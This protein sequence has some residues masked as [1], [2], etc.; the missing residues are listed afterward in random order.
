MRLQEW[1]RFPS[2]DDRRAAIAKAHQDTFRWILLPAPST[3]N[4]TPP[5]SDFVEWLRSGT[6]VY[7]IQGKMGCG[8]ST[9]MKYVTEQEL[10]KKHLRE[11]A[12]GQTLHC[13]SYYFSKIGTSE[14]QQSLQGLYRT[15]LATLIRHEKGLFRVAFPDRQASD[16]TH[17][18][19]SAVLRDALEKILTNSDITCKY[20]FFIDGL[21]E[22]QETDNGL[23]GELAEDILRLARLSAVKLVVASRP[24]PIF[25][26]NFARCLTMKLHNLTGNDIAAYVDARIRRRA[27]PHVLTAIDTREL[28]TLCVEVIQK[29]EGVFLWVTIAVASILTGIADYETLPELRS[30]FVQLDP[31]LSVLFKQVLTERIQASHRKQVARCLLAAIVSGRD[32][33]YWR[34]FSPANYA[35][36]QATIPHSDASNDHTT[37]LGKWN[38]IEAHIVDLQRSLPG[39]SCGLFLGADAWPTRIPLDYRV[40][41]PLSLLHSSL[42]EFLEERKTKAILLKEA[43]D[44]F[45][46]N[47]AIAVGRMADLVLQIEIAPTS[48]RHSHYST[49]DLLDILHSIE[50]AEISTYV[51]QTSLI[52]TFDNTLCRVYKRSPEFANRLKRDWNWDPLY[53]DH[54]ID[55]DTTRLA[56]LY[57]DYPLLGPQGASYHGSNILS[58]SIAFGFSCY[59]EYKMNACRGLPEKTGTPLL[60]YPLWTRTNFFVWWLSKAGMKASSFHLRKFGHHDENCHVTPVKLLLTAGADPNELCHGLTPWSVLL[61]RMCSGREED[62]PLQRLPWSKYNWLGPPEQS[63]QRFRDRLEVARL[64]LDH[65]ADPFYSM[66]TPGYTIS[67]QIFAELLER[68]CCDGYELNRCSCSHA[69]EIQPRLTELVDLVEERRCLKQ[70]MKTEG[71]LLLRGAWLVLVLAY[72]LQSCFTSSF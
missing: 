25:Q 32:N 53:E 19:T 29:A 31:K 22:Y 39:R 8:K 21:D 56:I 1:L 66:E 60:F 42:V 34:G 7:W 11:W 70:Q 36:V 20:C 5:G 37:L 59:L 12:N 14:L 13:P 27:L 46:V 41:R 16:F 45:Q 17:E 61:Q 6:G 23:R 28:K 15:L 2:I 54:I 67:P 35:V 4:T 55:S 33:A 24:E 52:S 47:E 69:R 65:G 26:L 44:D 49:L 58:I 71:E 43:G 62:F 30:R 64:M 3:N 48:V 18:P 50:M 10:T 40:V 57:S 72:I 51:K 9:L 63:L 68:Q 38:E